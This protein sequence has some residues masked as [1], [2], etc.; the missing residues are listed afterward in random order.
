MKKLDF[1]QFRLT[2]LGHTNIDYHEET[3]Y[4]IRLYTKQA[5]GVICVLPQ[6]TKQLED[7][8]WETLPKYNRAKR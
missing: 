1:L 3:E 7:G 8:T 5:D 2:V 6:R 4:N